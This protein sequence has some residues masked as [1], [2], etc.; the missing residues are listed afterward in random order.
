VFASGL[1]FFTVG[2]TG[3]GLTTDHPMTWL[4][5]GIYGVFTGCTDGRGSSLVSRCP[6]D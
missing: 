2:Y 4:L 5:I 1:V 3:P 6:K